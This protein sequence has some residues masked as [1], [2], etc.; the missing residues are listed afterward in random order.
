MSNP[1]FVR[2]KV[3]VAAALLAASVLGACLAQARPHAPPPKWKNPMGEPGEP[4]LWLDRLKGRYRVDGMVEVVVAHPDYENLRCAPLPPAP[5][6]DNPPP[7]PRPLCEGI[8]GM[9]DCVAVGDGTGVQCILNA[10]WEDLYEIVMEPPPGE[11]AGAFEVPGG[12]SNL[13][14]SMALF[15]LEPYGEGIRFMLV[16]AKGLA[17]GSSSG[18][19]GD[20]T[21]F[22]TPC[23][24]TPALISKMRLET[25]EDRP[26][27]TCER[28]IRI[29]AR[30]GGKVVNF[31]IDIEINEVLFTRQEIQLWRVT[32]PKDPLD[33]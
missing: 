7:P 27:K 32:V 18:V 2:T 13:A 10:K 16:D 28:N 19:R 9:V 20:R 22:R 11:K 25:L 24:N 6:E 17:E 26:L 5:G 1:V 33:F 30:P 21:S 14:P 3:L 23:V 15:G 12:V 29:D 8:S 31:S 4:D